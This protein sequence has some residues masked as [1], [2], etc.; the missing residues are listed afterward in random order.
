ML[1]EGNVTVLVTFLFKPGEAPAM[2]LQARD[3]VV[4][5]IAIDVIYSDFAASRRRSRPG[6]KGHGMVLP[7][8]VSASCWRLFPPS[9]RAQNVHP[10]IAINV[11]RTDAVRRPWSFFRNGV[12]NPGPGR[13]RGIGLGIAHI[14]YRFVHQLR[15]SIGIHV[16]EHRLLTLNHRHYFV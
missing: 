15:L 16:L 12:H 1:D 14:A 8:L 5:S 7:Q 11:A 4:Q 6:A 9:I 13:I 2:S 3:D 10:S